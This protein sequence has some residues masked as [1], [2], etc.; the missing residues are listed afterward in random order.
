MAKEHKKVWTK[1]WRFVRFG[2]WEKSIKTRVQIILN[3]RPVLLI[4]SCTCESPG[5]FAQ[6]ADSD[7][8]GLRWDQ[9]FCISCK[10]PSDTD[11]AVLWTQKKSMSE[12]VRWL[13]CLTSNEYLSNTFLYGLIS[14]K[15]DSSFWQYLNY[16]Y[17]ID[18]NAMWRKSY[19]AQFKAQSS[20]FLTSCVLPRKL[21]YF[22][23][24]CCVNNN[25]KPWIFLNSPVTLYLKVSSHSTYLYIC[26][27]LIFQYLTCKGL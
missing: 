23:I 6:S 9:R 26:N 5:N 17:F 14:G 19:K 15:F 2:R 7:F 13:K 3:V 18:W 10:L 24:S 21:N 12:R 16:P 8:I 1:W 25:S 11:D 4:L 27:S 22:S 20:Q